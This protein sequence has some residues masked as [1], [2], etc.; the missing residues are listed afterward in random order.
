MLQYIFFLTPV[1]AKE[2]QLLH[3]TP[4]IHS[5]FDSRIEPKFSGCVFLLVSQCLGLVCGR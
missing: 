2:M 4:Y 5:R 1:P 3:T